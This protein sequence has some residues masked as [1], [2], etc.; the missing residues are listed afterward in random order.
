MFLIKYG[1]ETLNWHEDRDEAFAL[2]DY[3]IQQGAPSTI[4][5]Y[6]TES[7]CRIERGTR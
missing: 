5:V 6:D 2:R 7:G 3:E 1:P 4:Y